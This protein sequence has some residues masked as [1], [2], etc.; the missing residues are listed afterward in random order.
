MASEETWEDRTT[1]PH[2]VI[3]NTDFEMS[4]GDEGGNCRMLV[5]KGNHLGDTIERYAQAE[6]TSDF[7]ERCEPS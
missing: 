5:A 4:M 7:G 2:L 1:G 3:R 6:P